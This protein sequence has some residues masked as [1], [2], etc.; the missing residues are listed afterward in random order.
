MSSERRHNFE[1][2]SIVTGLYVACLLI[3]NVAAAK[4]CQLGPFTF[5]GGQIIFPISYIFGD[6]LTEVYGFER[7][8]RVIWTGFASM[9]LAAV[10]FTIVRYLPPAEY[11]HN[12]D[13]FDKILG[14]TPRIMI[15]SIMAITVGEFA[16]S[17]VLSRLKWLSKGQVGWHIALRF[18]LS[19]MAGEAVDTAVFISAGFIGT[20]K[21]LTELVDVAV[22]QYTLK[23][24]Y[25]II[26][27]PLSIRIS[28][29]VKRVE[30]VDQ[31]DDP[32][33]VSYNPL[34]L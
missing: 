29:W 11:W 3:S 13:A 28:Q 34:A 22:G 10:V 19:T 20:G 24:G 12:Q 27:L 14:N 6:I 21:S 2:L 17:F 9:F 31:I 18:V 32:S 8:R 30:G 25:E 4:E 5:L 33:E 26:A 7:S 23:V 1:L 15:A 16:N